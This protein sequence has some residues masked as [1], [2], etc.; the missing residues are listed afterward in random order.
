[1]IIL[2]EETEWY[3]P[4]SVIFREKSEKIRSISKIILEMEKNNELEIPLNKLLGS[5]IHMMINRLFRSKQRLS[6]M[7][8]YDMLRRYYSSLIAKVKNSPN[9]ESVKLKKCNLMD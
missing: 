3:V 5:Y 9:K 8:I 7:V 4:I 2:A 1:M 6:E